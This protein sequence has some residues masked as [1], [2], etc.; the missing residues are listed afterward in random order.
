MV[1]TKVVINEKEYLIEIIRKKVKRYHLKI[2]KDKKIVFVI[3]YNISIIKACEVLESLKPWL[4]KHISATIINSSNDKMIFRGEVL[5]EKM[6]DINDVKKFL[7]NY[8]YI[9]TDLFLKCTE[10]LKV[11]NVNLRFKYYKSRWGCINLKNREVILNKYLLHF[12]DDV[13]KSVIYHELAHLKYSNHSKDFYKLLLTYDP[14][15]KINHK[16]L[17][18]Y[19]YVLR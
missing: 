9:L 15:Y 1:V 5:D 18:K 11:K 2:T 14:N 10:E 7:D 8:T 12:S 16:V 19:S 4:E 17:K 6:G 3:P 13:I